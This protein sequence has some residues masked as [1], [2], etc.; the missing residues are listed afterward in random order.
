LPAKIVKA[1]EFA[2][3]EE[4]KAAE[5]KRKYKNKVKQAANAFRKAKE[6]E[7]KAAR[8]AE[9]RLA[10]DLKQDTGLAKKI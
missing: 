2:E 4:E 10:K 9:Y 3:Q 1:R 5:E 6:Q 7:E 8:I